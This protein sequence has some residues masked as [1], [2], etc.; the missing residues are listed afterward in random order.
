[1]WKYL[2]KNGTVPMNDQTIAM[3]DIR[4][5]KSD[6]EGR[7]LT[8]EE[9]NRMIQYAAECEEDL[10]ILSLV[11]LAGGGG[12]RRGELAGLRWENVNFNERNIRIIDNRVQV[13]TKETVKRPKTNEIRNIPM[14]DVLF[15]TLKV[16][17]EWQEVILKREVTDADYV[18][19]TKINLINNYLPSTGKISRRFKEFEKRMNK[20]F[21]KAGEVEIEPVRLHDLRHTF[22]TNLMS[23]AFNS[24]GEWIEPA[25]IIQIHFASGHKIKS[26][27]TTA[28]KRYLHDLGFR[29]SITKFFNEAIEVDILPIIEE[30]KDDE[31]KILVG[32]KYKKYKTRKAIETR[33]K[34][35]AKEVKERIVLDNDAPLSDI[36]EF[37]RK[38]IVEEEPK[39]TTKKKVESTEA[40]EEKTTTKAEPTL[41]IASEPEEL[42]FK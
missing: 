13:G 9:F 11:L 16:V 12:L 42:I 3:A 39:K 35:A 36:H 26:A 5:V 29:D 40:V 27:D 38:E 32:E 22:V 6:F 17:K 34:R 31:G 15:N 28:T 21:L 18:Y 14:H 4:V 37:K 30:R 19:M 24:K 7:A 10:S 23:G 33:A 41:V 25:D 8:I 2:S 1:M 20:Y